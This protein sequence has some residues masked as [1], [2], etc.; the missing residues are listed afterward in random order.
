MKRKCQGDHKFPLQLFKALCVED[1]DKI[2]F[3]F[4]EKG[5]KKNNNVGVKNSRVI[6]QVFI[7]LGF[8]FLHELY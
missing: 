8:F 6:K 4:T 5:V 2:C 7:S 3:F 1:I